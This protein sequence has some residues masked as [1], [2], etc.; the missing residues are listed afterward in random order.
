MHHSH[1][2]AVPTRSRTQRLIP[3][4]IG[5]LAAALIVLALDRLE[6]VAWKT[7][8]S[9]GAKLCLPTFGTHR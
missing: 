9:A 8:T 3:L 6:Y 7:K 4:L 2:L 5:V 1:T